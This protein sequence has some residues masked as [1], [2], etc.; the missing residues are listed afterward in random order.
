MGHLAAGIKL[1]SWSTDPHLGAVQNGPLGELVRGNRS[2]VKEPSNGSPPE[3]G[4]HACW[5]ATRESIGSD[6]RLLVARINI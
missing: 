3:D 5:K 2:R 6:T 1:F 4:G